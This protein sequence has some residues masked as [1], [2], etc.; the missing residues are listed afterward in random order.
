MGAE[1]A[2]LM[3]PNLSGKRT[4]R[5]NTSPHGVSVVFSGVAVFSAAFLFLEVRK[6]THY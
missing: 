6:W 5:T 1:G 4:E 3:G 2:R